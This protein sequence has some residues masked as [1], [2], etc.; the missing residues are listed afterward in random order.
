MSDT[1]VAFAG[2]LKTIGDT[3]VSRMNKTD[4]CACQGRAQHL[5]ALHHAAEMLLAAKDIAAKRDD[6][7]ALQ[8]QTLGIV[9][10]AEQVF[11]GLGAQAPDGRHVTHYTTLVRRFVDVLT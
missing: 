1:V 9:Q 11:N 3:Y 6:N 4:A 5:D 2:D 8:T 7:L 10:E